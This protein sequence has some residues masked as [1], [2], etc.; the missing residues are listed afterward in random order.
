METELELER[1]SYVH[2][3]EEATFLQSVQLPMVDRSESPDD[4]QMSDISAS[5]QDLSSLATRLASID[6]DARALYPLLNAAPAMGASAPNVAVAINELAAALRTS[7]DRSLAAVAYDI[8]GVD[9]A[10][11]TYQRADDSTVQAS[12]RINRQ[13]P[14]TSGPSR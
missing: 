14:T 1:C 9:K 12:Q 5:W 10:M 2:C 8:Q 6:T 13:L 7:L 3:R 4:K 11:C